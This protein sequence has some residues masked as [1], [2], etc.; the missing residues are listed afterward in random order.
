MRNGVLIRVKT[1]RRKVPGTMV[2]EK[3]F[4]PMGGIRSKKAAPINP[5]DTAFMPE[6]EFFI[7]SR[8]GL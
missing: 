8:Q 5:T 7:T 2:M 3:R 6:R 4:I 1:S